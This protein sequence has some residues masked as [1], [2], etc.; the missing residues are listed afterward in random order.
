MLDG[1]HGNPT[2]GIASMVQDPLKR[3]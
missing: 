2:N 1:Y 3:W